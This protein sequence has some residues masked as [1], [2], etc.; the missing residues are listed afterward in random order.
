GDYDHGALWFAL[1]PTARASA[2]S[3]DVLFLGNSRMQFG[4][5]A[6]ALGRWFADNGFRYYLLGF[7]HRENATFVGPLVQG[8]HAKRRAYVINLDSF[9]TGEETLPGRDVMRGADTRVRYVAKRNW[10]AF[11]R[12]I[13]MR[14]PFLCGNAMSFYRQR[15]T[16][17]WRL[18]GSGGPNPV[19]AEA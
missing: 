19:D 9:F 6:P 17:E 13:C 15:E 7:S 14:L 3:A 10:Q 11:H 8:L 16:G 12:P 18:E 1:E 5:S 2:A 4:F